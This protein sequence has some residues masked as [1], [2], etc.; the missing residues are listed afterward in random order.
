MI[1][2]SSILFKKITLVNLKKGPFSSIFREKRTIFI[3]F[4]GKKDHFHPFSGKKGLFSSIFQVLLRFPLSKN[5][6]WFPSPAVSHRSN[7]PWSRPRREER[8]GAAG[9]AE[10]HGG[11]LWHQ[12]GHGCVTYSED[13]RLFFL[14]KHMR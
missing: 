12:R 5:H 8:D 1:N 14:G 3:H 4:P 10:P 13:R 2:N 6:D 9:T 7:P 11:R